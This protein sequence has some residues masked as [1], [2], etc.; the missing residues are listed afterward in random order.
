MSGWRLG[1]RSRK[2]LKARSAS[3]GGITV[4]RLFISKVKRRL[5]GTG[6]K[7]IKLNKNGEYGLCRG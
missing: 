5:D 1:G 7:E 3:L 4:Y 6:G 2:C